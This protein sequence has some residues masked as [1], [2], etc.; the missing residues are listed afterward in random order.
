MKS[1]NHT[2]LGFRGLLAFS[3]VIYHIF[4]SAG[5]EGYIQRFSED[6]V[7]YLINYAGVISVDLFFVISGYLIMQSLSTKRTLRQFAI[8][9]L[10]RIYPVFLTIHLIIFVVGPLIGYKW[11]DGI[12]VGAYVTHFVSNS[13]LLPGMLELP[14]AQIV[15][16]S[17]SYEMFF[18]IIAGLIW[19]TYRSSKIRTY[20]KYSLYTLM[21][22]SSVVIVYFHR[23]ALFFV[24]GVAAYY[25]QT[26][27]KRSGER[28]KALYLDG[29]I[30]L[31]AIYAAFH[32]MKAPLAVALGLSFL[33]FRTIIMEYGLL[34]LILRTKLMNY[35][36]KI[37]FS[38]YMWHTM[39][40]F[41]LK[42]LMPKLSSLMDSS[43]TSFVLYMLMSLV[44][45]LIVSHLS[46][47]YIETRFTRKKVESSANSSI[48]PYF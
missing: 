30:Y 28:H 25:S 43:S 48:T 45:S 3:V 44:L 15:A 21:F 10:L 11:M 47:N 32:V 42:K 37:S 41:P 16:W 13:L 18:Y 6:S 8:N 34:S 26:K 38:L 2:L 5:I 24:V 4:E 9:R 33:L 40:M 19:F 1:I 14:I 35:L 36:G 20:G 27:W 7:L 23:D 46:Y 22:F 39:V 29:M 31:V 17:L 12:S